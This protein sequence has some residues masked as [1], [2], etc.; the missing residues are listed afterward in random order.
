[1]RYFNLFCLLF[2]LSSCSKNLTPFNQDLYDKYRWSNEELKNIQF[3]L[4]DD[5]VLYKKADNSEAS[6]S[7]G[8]INIKKEK[9][10]ERII[11]KRGTPG[12]FVF[13][14]KNNRFAISFS[15]SGDDKYLMFGPNE[16]LN[17]K[18]ALLAKEWSKYK[19]TVT[20]NDQTYT[21]NS[22][23]ALSVLLVDLKKVSKYQY[24]DKSEKGR[25]IE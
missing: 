16:A 12:V 20:Y 15:Q 5:I 1:M 24:S 10:G 23:D 9:S 3:Y 6:I 22:D 25:R 19:G 13:S 8:Q 21:V 2:I 11:I 17:G 7:N 14:P 18:F 4:S